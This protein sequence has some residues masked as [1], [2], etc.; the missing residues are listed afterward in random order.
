MVET[1]GVLLGKGF[2]ALTARFDRMR[3]KRNLLLYDVGGLIS[4][5]EAEEAFKTAGHYLDKV[6]DHM[7]WHDPQLRFE[8][9]R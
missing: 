9:K 7:E 2:A 1:A 5:A 4:H 6:R 8:F 3:K